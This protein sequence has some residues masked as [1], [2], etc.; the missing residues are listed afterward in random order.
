MASVK[1]R[2]DGTWRARYRDPQ[3]R[4]H[5]RHFARRADAERWLDEVRGDLARGL[6]TDPAR[7]RMTFGAWVKD[8]FADNYPRATTNARD[9]VVTRCHLLPSLSSR[10]LSA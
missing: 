4:E 1:R 8:Y 6:W 9:Q 5:A 3:G 2:S 10:P 7:S